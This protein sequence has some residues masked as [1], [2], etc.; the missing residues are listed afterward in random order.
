METT[1]KVSCDCGFNPDK[2]DGHS[3]RCALAVNAACSEA[4]EIA[5]ANLNNV[6]L[7]LYSVLS[8]KYSVLLGALEEIVKNDPFNQSSAGIIERAA[9]AKSANGG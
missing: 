5:D 8:A 4:I 7:P 6:D 1:K 3:L 2:H 9:I